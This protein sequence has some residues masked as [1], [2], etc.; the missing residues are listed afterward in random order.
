MTTAIAVC[1][2]LGA[3]QTNK[4]PIYDSLSAY[5]VDSSLALSAIASQLPATAIISLLA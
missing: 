1:R 2:V 5:I 4:P 3:G